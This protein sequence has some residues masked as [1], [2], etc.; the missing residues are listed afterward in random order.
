M[1]NNEHKINGHITQTDLAMTRIQHIIIYN[2][3]FKQL[4][5]KSVHLS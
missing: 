4:A 5:W 2:T 3:A 1:S